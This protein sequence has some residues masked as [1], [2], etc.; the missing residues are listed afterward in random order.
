M[1]WRDKFSGETGRLNRGDLR[2]A[3]QILTGHASINYHLH[4]YK[5]DI[6]NKTCPFCQEEDETINHFIGKCPQWA[7]LRGQFFNTFYASTSEILDMVNLN[8]IIQYA[9]ATRRLDPDFEPPGS[10]ANND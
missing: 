10:H 4:K 7:A 6:I 1:M 2:I 5:P 9:K 8:K 3:T